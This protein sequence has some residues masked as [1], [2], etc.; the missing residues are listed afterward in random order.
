MAGAKV[1]VTTISKMF[2]APTATTLSSQHLTKKDKIT[3]KIS[4][5]LLTQVQTHT[6]A[7]A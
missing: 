6:H 3:P 1:P 4:N 2:L 7:L 5:T